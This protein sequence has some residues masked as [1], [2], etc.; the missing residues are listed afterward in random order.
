MHTRILLLLVA[1]AVGVRAQVTI[2]IEDLAPMTSAQLAARITDETGSGALV[3]AGGNIGAATG[4]SLV[5]GANA[6]TNAVL[7]LN[8]SSSTT[9]AVIFQR[10]GV[11]AGRIS[12]PGSATMTFEVPTAAFTGRINTVGD[13]TIPAGALFQTPNYGL[14]QTGGV[15]FIRDLVNGSMALR[16][17]P[18][19]AP[20]VTVVH[21]LSVGGNITASGVGTHFFAG[22]LRVLNGKALQIANAGSS[23]WASFTFSGSQAN[24][25]YPFSV[26]TN[27]DTAQLNIEGNS[28]GT[29]GGA[30]LNIRNGAGNTVLA[31]GNYSNLHG[32]SYNATPEIYFSGSSLLLYSASA[33]TTALTL[34]SNG[35]VSATGT[36][37]QSSTSGA[38]VFNAATY[39]VDKELFVKRTGV[40]DWAVRTAAGT[41]NLEFV[42]W[43]STLTRLS[44]TP[45][46]AIAFNGTSAI[47]GIKTGTA[48]FSQDSVSDGSGFNTSVSVASVTASDQVLVCMADNSHVPDGCNLSGIANGS[49]T[50]SVRLF[51]RSGGTVTGL[52]SRSFRYTVILY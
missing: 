35:N 24:V 21:G 34:G 27:S 41:G 19:A 14:Y 46:G 18:S 2:P 29:A 1:L 22:D 15:F 7:T 48:V 28:S 50:I 43:T 30:S 33:G 17:D 16:V 26:G 37:S 51:N 23:A 4:T 36:L 52:S 45:A 40:Q 13:V 47:K 10:G 3:F 5:L 39:V 12:F 9:Q 32:G 20:E 38:N 44:L 6:A 49:G 42:D 25:N 11:E 31:F 8:S